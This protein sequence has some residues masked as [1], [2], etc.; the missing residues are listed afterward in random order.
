MLGR[1]EFLRLLFAELNVPYNEVMQG[2]SFQDGYGIQQEMKKSHT[3]FAIPAIEHGDIF[4]W[5]TPVMARYIALQCDEGRLMP[6]NE[7]DDLYAQALMATLVD[8]VGEGHD[9]W[10]SPDHNASYESQKESS[11]LPI[12]IFIEKR[13]PKF[14]DF[15]ENSLKKNGNQFFVGQSL[16]Y[17]DVCMFHWLD[18][19][20]YQLPEVYQQANIPTLREFKK[21]IAQRPNIAKRLETRTEKYDGT[22]PIF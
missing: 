9:A 2:K 3:F 4:L 16:S 12:K 18:G 15:F 21:R 5:Q 13:L 17:V 1:G 22:G 8:V 7:K 20:E 11:A 14:F 10:H 6:K 19:I